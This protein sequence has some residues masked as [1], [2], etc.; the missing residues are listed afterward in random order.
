MICSVCLKYLVPDNFGHHCLRRTCV[1][2]MTAGVKADE[3]TVQGLSRY[4]ECDAAIG[5]GLI[6]F[7]VTKEAIPACSARELAACGC[8]FTLAV[9][10]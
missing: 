2:L 4:G 7:P 1:I 8:W 9:S 6:V 10:K 5:V 3:E